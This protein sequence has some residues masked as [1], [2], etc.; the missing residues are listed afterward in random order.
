MASQRNRREDTHQRM[1]MHSVLLLMRKVNEYGLLDDVKKEKAAHQ[2]KHWARAIQMQRVDEPKNLRQQIKGHQA[3]Q[4]TRRKAHNQIE[5]IAI[6][7]PEETAYQ[8]REE[9]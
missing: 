5:M 7:Q 8:R 6:A 4:Y 2:C 3:D 9:R 1:L